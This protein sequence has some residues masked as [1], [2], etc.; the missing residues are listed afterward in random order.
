MKKSKVGRNENHYAKGKKKLGVMKKGVEPLSLC[1]Y[2][3]LLRN[4]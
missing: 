1:F 2:S 4:P 3:F